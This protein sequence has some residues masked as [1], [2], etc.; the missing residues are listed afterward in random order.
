MRRSGSFFLKIFIEKQVEATW[1]KQHPFGFPCACLGGEPTRRLN[2]LFLRESL[3]GYQ[4]SARVFD[5]KGH[6]A[7]NRVFGVLC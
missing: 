3:V 2:L 6:Q 7:E 5:G 4:I 1:L